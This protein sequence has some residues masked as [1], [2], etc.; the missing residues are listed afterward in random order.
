M[1]TSFIRRASSR[2]VVLGV[3]ALLLSLPT[4]A[5]HAAAPDPQPPHED[6]LNYV[7]RDLTVTPAKV[8]FDHHTVT[9]T[10]TLAN[11]YADDS[12]KPPVAGQTVDLVQWGII[13]QDNPNPSVPSIDVFDRLGTVTTDARGHFRLA[14]AVI[15]QRIPDPFG[16]QSVYSVYVYAM[17]RL[18][19]AVYGSW[20]TNSHVSVESTASATRLRAGYKVGPRI[21]GTRKVTAEGYWER[22][23]GR[24]WKPLKG[25]TVTVY[26]TTQDPSANFQGTATTGADGHF[27]L[28]FTA[29]ADGTA[30]TFLSSVPAALASYVDSPTDEMAWQYVNVSKADPTPTPTPTPTPSHHATP[31]P[32]PTPTHDSTPAPSPTSTPRPTPAPSTSETPTPGGTTPDTTPTANAPQPLAATGT[33]SATLLVGSAAL[34]IAGATLVTAVRRRT[35]QN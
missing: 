14:N 34:A 33:N 10:G 30:T 2:G 35:R 22:K 19:P 17:R 11:R 25:G 9:V 5:V 15:D 24:T 13:T 20:G 12:A 28:T 8:D 23:D 4:S 1:L 27:S 29:T 32:T 7:F 3:L 31:T 26:Y 16:N 18:D 6:N 21:D